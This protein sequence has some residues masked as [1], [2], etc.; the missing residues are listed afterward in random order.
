MPPSKNSKPKAKKVKTASKAAT[1]ESA[2]AQTTAPVE[3]P[4]PATTEPV[5]EHSEAVDNSWDVI[6][7][8]KLYLHSSHLGRQKLQ[9]C[10]LMLESSKRAFREILRKT[11]KR[12]AKRR[13]SMKISQREL[14]VDLLSQP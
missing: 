1:H 6:S 8:L 10:R 11:P 2:P 4:T 14:Q 13:K 9:I 7:S 5:S 12:T 3:T